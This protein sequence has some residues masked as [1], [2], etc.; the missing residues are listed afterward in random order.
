M[1][2]TAVILG[3]VMSAASLYTIPVNDI[4]GKPVD[5]AQY[6]GHPLLIV[7]TA[8]QC[9]YTP[10]YEPLQ[11]LQEKYQ[12]QGLRVLA[13]PS[14]DFGGQ[15]PGSNAEVKS[16]CLNKYA[17]TFKLFEKVHAKAGAEQHPIFKLLSSAP[18]GAAPKWNFTKYLVDHEGNLVKTYPS[19]VDPLDAKLV[20]DVETA[21][22]KSRAK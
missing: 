16:F 14:N 12:A 4:D 11:D 21:L 6:K 7:N 18:H 1:G 17:V 20:A 10:Q 15:E 22:A 3:A 19:A 13:F 9:G 2:F 5:L 8:S